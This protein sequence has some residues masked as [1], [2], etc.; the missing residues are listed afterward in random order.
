VTE[1]PKVYKANTPGE[2]IFPAEADTEMLAAVIR[3]CPSGALQYTRKDGKAEEVPQVNMLRLRENGPYAFRGELHVD[4]KKVGYRATLCRCG[5]SSNKP[6]CD[7]THISAQFRATGEPELMSDEPLTKRDGPLSIQRTENGPYQLEGPLEI[8]G[9][10][11]H[12]VLRCDA[13][14]LCRCGHSKSKPVCDNSHVVANF[15]DSAGIIQTA[16]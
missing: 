10:T 13:V 4:G 15:K 5:M 7:G 8:C 11:G 3:E 14:R 9:G 12:I 16:P 6:F 2:W 1:L